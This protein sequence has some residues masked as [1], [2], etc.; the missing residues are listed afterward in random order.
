MEV[1]AL[2][3]G[4]RVA[5]LRAHRGWSRRELARRSGLSATYVSSFERGLEPRPLPRTLEALAGALGW[6]SFQSLVGSDALEPPVT[7]NDSGAPPDPYRVELA[8]FFADMAA[9]MEDLAQQVERDPGA[10]R[11]SAVPN[12]IRDALVAGLAKIAPRA[13]GEGAP[14]ASGATA[15]QP[16][17]GERPAG[18]RPVLP[19]FPWGSA[20]DDG[21]APEATRAVAELAPP[22]EFAAHIGPDGFGVQ[23]EGTS[24]AGLGATQGAVAWVARGRDW[25]PGD[26]VAALVDGAGEETPRLVV[27]L[28]HQAGLEPPALWRVPE[29]GPEPCAAG[30]QRVL[31]K[32]VCIEPPRPRPFVPRLSPAARP[33]IKR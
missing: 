21:D 29:Q 5:R 15:H 27:A 33:G 3:A 2:A 12:A 8:A 10:A 22:G 32:V 24:L 1:D 30:H 6:S 19:V 16:G 13:T 28:Y 17:A 31:G 26:A 23:I 11:P 9:R 7:R 18:S 20:G 25:R 14:R 4:Q